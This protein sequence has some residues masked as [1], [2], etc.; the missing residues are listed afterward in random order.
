MRLGK[1]GLGSVWLSYS[2]RPYKFRWVGLGLCWERK[3]VNY[4]LSLASFGITRFWCFTYTGKYGYNVSLDIGK[5]RIEHWNC[6]AFGFLLDFTTR[7]RL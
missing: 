6:H 2:D 3:G 7:R 1:V 4:T 5:F